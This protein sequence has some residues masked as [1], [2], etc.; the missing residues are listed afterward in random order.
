VVRERALGEREE[1]GER[2]GEERGAS[3]VAGDRA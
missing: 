3:E 2:R 1:D